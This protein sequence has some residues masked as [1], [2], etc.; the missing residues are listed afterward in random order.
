[1]QAV[2]WQRL[3]DGA[4]R[5]E[6]FTDTADTPRYVETFLVES[7]MDHLRQHKRVTPPSARPIPVR[8]R[9]TSGLRHHG[10]RS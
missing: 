2:R 10:W 6:L 1:M 9:S 3:P 5:W 7:E 4:R 8:I